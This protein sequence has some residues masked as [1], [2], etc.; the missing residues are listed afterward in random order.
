MVCLLEATDEGIGDIFAYASREFA[1]LS[2]ILL[3]FWG[4]FNNLS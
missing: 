1:D 3:N 2:Y 4:Y